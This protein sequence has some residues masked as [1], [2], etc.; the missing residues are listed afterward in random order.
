MTVLPAPPGRVLDTQELKRWVSD[1]A[2]HPEMWQE[3]VRHDTGGRHYASVYRDSDID[4]WVLCWNTADDTGWH[5]HDTSSGAV[6]VTRG[7][8]T[9]ATPRMGGEPVTR[10]V[11]AGRTF[12]FGPDHIHRMGG[13]VDGSVTIH[14]YSPPLW[15]MGQYSISRSGV[16]RRKAVSYADELRPIDE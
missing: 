2:A 12:A 3:H 9:E 5:D 10:V 15:R 7:A 13:A 6:A 14:A 4:V 11:E 16:L 8:V 1:F